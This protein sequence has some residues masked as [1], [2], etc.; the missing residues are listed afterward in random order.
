MKNS[1]AKSLTWICR[2]AFPGKRVAL[3]IPQ[4][5]EKTH[6]DIRERL[7]YYDSMARKYRDWLD[8]ILIDDGSGD[9]S[10]TAIQQFIAEKES[11]LLLAAVFPN[12]RKV[13]ALFATAL[14]ISHEW[15]ITSDF[16]TD[17]HGLENLRRYLP[18]MRD[19]SVMGGY[20]RMLPFEGNGSIF[21]FQQLEYTFLRGLYRWHRKDLSVRVMPGAG[22]CYKR[23][24][25]V[26]LFKDHSGL[27]NGEDRETTILGIKKGYRTHYL[28]K[29]Q[30]LT[31]PPLTYRALL[32][33][34]VRWN[35][36]YLETFGKERHWY[37][38]QISSLTRTG[39]LT[40][41]DI[42]FVVTLLVSPVL[43]LV[44]SC[45]HWVPGLSLLVGVVI[46]GICWPMTGLLGARTEYREIRRRLAKASFLFPFIKLS[47]EWTA[48]M[49]V[50]IL[51]RQKTRKRMRAAPQADLRVRR[52]KPASHKNSLL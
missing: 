18:L 9:G 37:L 2:P 10:L 8:L 32:R 15:V 4:Y 29:V 30:A 22:S 14:N 13:G 34:R 52:R 33:Q 43:I 49:R 20:F 50:I 7:Y 31:R 26:K 21:L 3:L 12:A 27:R 25:L 28:P 36:G 48:W 5:N 51:F 45:F 46:A 39:I 19:P 16:D 1:I 40:L 24:I 44:M 41:F 6:C 11:L 17:L 35:L 42:L 23:E 47:I 38:R